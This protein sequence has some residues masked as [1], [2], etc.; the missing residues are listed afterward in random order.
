[1]GVRGYTYIRGGD[2]TRVSGLIFSSG[3][4]RGG[5]CVRTGGCTYVSVWLRSQGVGPG[6]RVSARVFVV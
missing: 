2:C 5:G 6:V 1:M 4:T 3:C